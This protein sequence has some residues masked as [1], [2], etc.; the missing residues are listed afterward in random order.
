MLVS[1]YSYSHW[2]YHSIRETAGTKYIN[3]IIIYGGSILWYWSDCQILTCTQSPGNFALRQILVWRF[4]VSLMLGTLWET[5]ME[6]YLR[7]RKFNNLFSLPNQLGS[8]LDSNSEQADPLVP[9][10]ALCC[11]QLQPSRNVAPQP[12]CVS[13][14]NHACVSAHENTVVEQVVVLPLTHE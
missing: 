7:S 4:W 14:K 5:W 2:A 1:G 13:S 9:K 11:P 12:L 6:E 8:I 3:N 10:H